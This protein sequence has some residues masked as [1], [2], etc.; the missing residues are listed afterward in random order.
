MKDHF[1]QRETLTDKL[2][3]KYLEAMSYLLQSI[4]Q[5]LKIGGNEVSAQNKSGFTPKKE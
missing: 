5:V 1:V 2:K 3:E 4:N